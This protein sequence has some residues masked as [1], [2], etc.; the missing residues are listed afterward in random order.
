M[1]NTHGWYR[2]SEA[3]CLNRITPNS[4]ADGADTAPLKNTMS[5]TLYRLCPPISRPKF[6]LFFKKTQFFSD[7]CLVF[8]LNSFLLFSKHI[9]D[10]KKCI[11][12]CSCFIVSGDTHSRCVKCPSPEACN[13]DSF[14]LDCI[15]LRWTLRSL[16]RPRL[17]FSYLVAGGAAFFHWPLGW[18]LKVLET[19]VFSVFD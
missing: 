18:N 19:A 9:M 14:G 7:P 3:D 17:T 6:F 2:L 16:E 4:L 8:E 10:F 12:P 11:P 13:V 15:L 5:F 1:G